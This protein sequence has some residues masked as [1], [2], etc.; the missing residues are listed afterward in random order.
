MVQSYDLE[1]VADKVKA[2]LQAN[3]PAEI[4]AVNTEKGGSIILT[5][6]AAYY[7]GLRMIDA[8]QQKGKSVVSVIVASQDG[9]D[10]NPGITEENSYIEVSLHSWEG[11]AEEVER[12]ILRYGRALRNVLDKNSVIKQLTPHPDNLKDA[13]VTN[14]DYGILEYIGD[15]YMKSV[16]IRLRVKDIY[17]Y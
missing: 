8:A 16:T 11:T 12:K 3:L 5:N 4:I 10:F 13:V 2:I 15:I 14:I 1:S 17:T 7:F 9:E 6:P